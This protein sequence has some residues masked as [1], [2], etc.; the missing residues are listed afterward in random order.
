MKKA[1]WY[2]DF[3]SPFAYLQLARLPHLSRDLEITPVPIV[4]G[5]LLKHW[6][7]LGPA[8]ILPKRRYVY[9]YFQWQAAQLDIPF[10]MPASHPFNPLPALR[11]C[12]A[13]G[14]HLEHVQAVFR[15]IFGNGRQPDD[16]ETITAIAQALHI[17]DPAAALACTAVKDTL[18]ENTAKAIARGVFGVP[19]FIIDDEIF[20]GNDSTDMMLD[21][22]R[23]PS[24]FQS[25][26]MQRVSDM[27]MGLQR[28]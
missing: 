28:K 23:S 1:N 25:P 21:Y 26:E 5:A 15:I 12:I 24:I 14:A 22:I 3:I 18:R 19:T 11:L 20:W 8:E 27:P 9:R 17:A 13:A 2:F 4:F 16:P 6:G 10:V 7:Q